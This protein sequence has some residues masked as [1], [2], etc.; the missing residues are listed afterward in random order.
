MGDGGEGE[1][2]WSAFGWGRSQGGDEE[3]EEEGDES[4]EGEMMVVVGGGRTLAKRTERGTV[5]VE[6]GRS[7]SGK[8]R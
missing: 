4:S 3:D 6:L 2:G 1:G 7:G 8:A 5:V